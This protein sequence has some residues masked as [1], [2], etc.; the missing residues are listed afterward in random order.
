MWEPQWQPIADSGRRVIRCDLRGYGD[1][2]AATQPYHDV[3]DA[4]E[5]LDA[6][7]VDSVAVVGASF[8]GQVAL[9]LAAHR[10][11][12]VAALVL[13][14]AA[15]I[16]REP[17]AEL[18]SF[19]EREDALLE[20]GD[21]DAAVELNVDTWLGPEADAATR[22]QVRRM[23]RHAFDVQLAADPEFDQ[24][25]WDTEL[26]D[27]TAATLAVAGRHD[28]P[29]FRQ[30]AAALPDLIPGARHREL[31]WAGHLPSL[32]R[33]AAATE[34]LLEFLGEQYPSRR[35]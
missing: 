10:P 30:F 28:L 31:D 33:P 1:T 15:P 8:G 27:V 22:E 11:E 21:V 34:L 17:S 18:Q 13:L 35:P 29:D 23:Q 25:E 24:H 19:D 6:L 32:E 9:R 16:G 4:A 3:A 12:K 7:D 14:G 5:L 2:P 26:S 20:S